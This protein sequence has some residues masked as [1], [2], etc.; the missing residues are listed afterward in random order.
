[1]NTR[2][3][4]EHPVTE[5]VTGLD[6]VEWMIRV[7]AGEAL[8]FAQRDVRLDGWA[9]EARVYAED[10]ERDFLPATGR[11]LKYRPP[12]A[13]PDPG[14]GA[15]GAAVDAPAGAPA[16][17]TGGAAGRSGP[18]GAEG[19]GGAPD[20][21]GGPFVPGAAVRVDDGVEEGGEIAVWYDPMIAKLVTSGRDRDEALDR[22]HTALDR[23]T[24]RGVT[25]NLAFLAALAATPRSAPATS[26]PRSSTSTS[27]AGSR[28]P[29]SSRRSPRASSRPRPGCSRR[30]TG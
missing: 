7:A 15:D 4:V 18:G 10:P 19:E 5:A 11:L 30:S 8:P 21:E 3:Q 23:Y 2:L 25:T 16:G 17:A 28:R 27:R 12:R 24:V 14:N 29:G 9:M 6:L 26:P 1:M 22:L 20:P 13:R